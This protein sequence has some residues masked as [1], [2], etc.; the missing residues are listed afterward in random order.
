MSASGA[1]H[2]PDTLAAGDVVVLSA[3]CWPIE[4]GAVYRVRVRERLR[5]AFLLG[6]VILVIR[7][8]G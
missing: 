6:R 8:H 3:K 1:A 2:A 7:N 5:P 4:P